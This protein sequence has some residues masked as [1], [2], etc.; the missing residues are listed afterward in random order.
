MIG[1]IWSP[2]A[3]YGFMRR[4][5]AGCLALSAGAAPLGTILLLRRMSLVGDAMSHAILP[6]AALGYLIFGLSLP[7][8]SI[9]GLLAGLLV[10]LLSGVVTRHTALRED[11]SFAGFYLISLAL[12]VLLI[13]LRGSNVDLLHVLFGS[14]LALDDP[15]LLLTA[16]IATASLLALALIYRPLIVECFDPGFL[17]LQGRQGELAHAVFMALLVLN[18]VGGFHSLG[19]LMSVAFVVLPAAAARF[20]VRGVGPQM[21]M[22]VVVAVLGSVIGL[23][24][25]F[26]VGIAASAAITLSLGSLYALSLSVGPL[27]SVLAH[28]RQAAQH[29]VRLKTGVSP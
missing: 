25:S 24:V 27:G 22:A 3:E 9:G 7:A 8:M 18:L 5:L 11:A 4:A 23:L 17:R 10:A 29:I 15:T 21:A 19:T 20:W 12:G 13:S 16:S 14:V 6:G 2:F 1:E 26:H 28:R